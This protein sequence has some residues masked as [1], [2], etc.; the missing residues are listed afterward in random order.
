MKFPFC[1]G[2]TACREFWRLFGVVK[3]KSVECM[4]KFTELLVGILTAYYQ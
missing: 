2:F 3:K 1:R 4:H